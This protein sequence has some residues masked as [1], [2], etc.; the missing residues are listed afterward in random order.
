MDDQ[1]L[2]CAGTEEIVGAA[3]ERQRAG[4]LPEA[5][6]LCEGVVARNGTNVDALHLLGVVRHQQGDH[7]RAVELIGRAIRLR[8]DFAAAHDHLGCA[9]RALGRLDESRAAYLE[10]IRL[11]PGL[12]V[13]HANLG[14]VFLQE[15]QLEEARLRLTRAT[16]LE[17]DRAIYWEYLAELFESVERFDSS[18]PCRERVLALTPGAR[19]RPHLALARALHEENRL[20][21]AESHCRAAAA[22]EPD[23]APAWLELGELHEVRGEFDR[24]EAAYRAAVRLQ[25]TFDQA[26]AVLATLLGARLPDADLDALVSRLDHPATDDWSR[27]RL[28]FALGQV[29]DARGD[30]PRAARCLREANAL[31]LSLSRGHRRFQPADHERTVEDLT[32]A[33]GPD[34][35]ARVAGGGL[36]TRRPVFIV[37]LPRSGTT[38]LEQILASHPGVV[39]LGELRLSRRLFESLPA[40]LRRTSSPMDCVALL[41]PA[42]TRFLAQAYSERLDALAGDRAE[43]VVDKLPGN[44]MH[45]G[46]LAALFPSATVIHCRRDPRDV[47]LSCWM[48]DF[49]TVP[50]SYDAGHVAAVFRGYLRLIDHWRAVL[51]TTIHEVDYEE[52]VSDLPR[53]ARRLFG[54]LGFDWDPACLDFHLSPRPVRTG[55]VAQVRQ[56]LYTRSVGR[57]K[58][59][60]HELADLFVA[61]PSW[62]PVPGEI[63]S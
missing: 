32:R 42:A 58:R 55:S 60:E 63:R 5:A 24:A 51:P 11:A 6:A 37:G 48:A 2:V 7:A 13:A 14:L 49:R 3:R 12:A 29:L 28:L 38:L 22:I 45:L 46:L 10:A 30:Y 21:E 4:R 62:R 39:G 57:W 59:Y 8:P 9:L 25:P 56:P 31:S 16:E 27:A 50:W 61:L 36:D 15:G 44:Y 23:S 20:D 41:D 54:A 19:A 35:F 33:F 47:A 43:R 34:F 52:T 18:I 17:P 40:V 1:G 53:V 26:R